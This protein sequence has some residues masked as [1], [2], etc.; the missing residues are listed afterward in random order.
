MAAS[1]H[2]LHVKMHCRVHHV[3]REDN[4]RIGSV[5]VALDGVVCGG[6]E[7]LGGRVISCPWKYT[8]LKMLTLSLAWTS[9]IEG[10]AIALL[11]KTLEAS[12]RRAPRC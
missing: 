2:S 10:V 12:R 6:L 11:I 1:A 8:S 7:G 9:L 5:V 4:G 3:L